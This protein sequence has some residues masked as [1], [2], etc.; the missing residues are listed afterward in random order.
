[1]IPWSRYGVFGGVMT[2]GT[3]VIG[4]VGSLVTTDPTRRKAAIGTCGGILLL[5]LGGGI[6]LLL[7]T[8]NSAMRIDSGRLVFV[9]GTG[10]SRRFAPGQIARICRANLNVTIRASYTLSYYLF[11]DDRGR[12]A[13]KLP[14]KWWP[15]NGIE[16]VAQTL[17]VG[18]SPSDDVLDGPAFR[19]A[20]PGSIP[21]VAAHPVLAAWLIGTGV[22]LAFIAV[23]LIFALIGAKF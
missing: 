19:R 15:E 4:L 12:T 1:M 13:F 23:L 14:V 21:W 3:V 10:W 6:R 20:F 7:I 11:V 5:L 2:A 18:F 16:A 8:R 17:G 9:N 22:F